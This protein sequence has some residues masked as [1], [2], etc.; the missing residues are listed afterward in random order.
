M[1]CGWTPKPAPAI[2]IAV[3][4][5]DDFNYEMG[6]N[7]LGNFR[8][9]RAEDIEQ[10]CRRDVDA[11]IADHQQANVAGDTSVL[12][13]LP[14]GDLINWLHARAEFFGLK[15]YGKS[16][17]YK[18]VI[19]N[20]EAWL[21]WHHDFRKQLLFIQRVRLFVEDKERRCGILAILLLHAIHEAKSWQ[22]PTVVTWDSGTEICGALALLKNKYERFTFVLEARRRETVSVRWKDGVKKSFKVAPNEHYAWN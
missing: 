4:L 14:T 22:L 13:I 9:L 18:G 17:L 10:L 11:L 16:P 19:Y 6:R 21:Y 8:L 12:T 20:T 1:R 5:S 2:R 15:V 7:N 3:N